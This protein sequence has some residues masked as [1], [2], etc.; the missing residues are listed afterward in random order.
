M[1]LLQL[2]SREIATAILF[3]AQNAS[4][5]KILNSVREEIK[6]TILRTQHFLKDASTKQE[7]KNQIR[8]KIVLCV[9]EIKISRFYLLRQ[10]I[11]FGSGSLW[12][13]FWLNQRHK[14]F[15]LLMVSVLRLTKIISSFSGMLS[16]SDLSSRLF[17]CCYGIHSCRLPATKKIHSAGKGK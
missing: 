11:S 13:T 5:I 2:P 12:T 14:A 4:Q 17:P 1:N 9:M 6:K 7:R 8:T 16:D 3:I 15:E 10:I